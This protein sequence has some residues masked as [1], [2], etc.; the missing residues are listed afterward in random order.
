M[1]R[2]IALVLCL[3]FT[4]RPIAAYAA[5][6]TPP[7]GA[8]RLVVP[9]HGVEVGVWAAQTAVGHGIGVFERSL[10]GT[11]W[12]LCFNCIVSPELPTMDSPVASMG[13]AGPYVASKL[14]AI[15]EVLARR[16][17]QV[18]PPLSGSTLDQVN[19]ALGG[20][21]VLRMVNGAPAIGPR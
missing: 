3:L 1:G 5:T 12:K 2:I 21:Y 11:E 14:E 17:P 19:G 16:Y 20:S 15:N 8:P 6:Y 4:V 18:A 10:N 9:N 7:A 13:G